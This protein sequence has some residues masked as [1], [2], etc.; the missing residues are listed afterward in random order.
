M[1]LKVGDLV[2]CKHSAYAVMWYP[3]M[4]GQV[5]TVLKVDYGPNPS[6]EN[7]LFWIH[8]SEQNGMRGDWVNHAWTPTLWEKVE[9]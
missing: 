4:A 5:A 9:T 6:G 8:I 7:D 3:E 1:R 2:K